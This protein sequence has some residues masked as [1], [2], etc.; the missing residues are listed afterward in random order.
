MSPPNRR[1]N[2]IKIWTPRLRLFEEDKAVFDQE[3]F[4]TVFDDF[5]T[6]GMV[7]RNQLNLWQQLSKTLSEHRWVGAN[8]SRQS[9]TRPL[10]QELHLTDWLCFTLGA[11]IVDNMPAD[12]VARGGKLFLDVLYIRFFYNGALEGEGLAYQLL[13]AAQNDNFKKYFRAFVSYFLLKEVSIHWTLTS[14]GRITGRFCTV[15]RP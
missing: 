2:Y 10:L 11:D 14:S 4:A 8:A 9:M 1:P 12:A 15:P 5:K 13:E 3:P 6:R 7:T